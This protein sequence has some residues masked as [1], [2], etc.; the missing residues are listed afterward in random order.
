MKSTSTPINAGQ[1]ALRK[2]HVYV[3]NVEQPEFD[4]DWKLFADCLHEQEALGAVREALKLGY[5]HA[6][7]CTMLTFSNPQDEKEVA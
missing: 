3:T 2:I 7:L 5:Y 6:R 1:A 4:K